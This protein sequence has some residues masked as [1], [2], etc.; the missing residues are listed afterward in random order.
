MGKYQFM[1]NA[2][3]ELEVGIILLFA[4]GAIIGI[5]SFSNLLSCVLRNFPT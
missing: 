2:V 5:V 1:M 3:S 4:V